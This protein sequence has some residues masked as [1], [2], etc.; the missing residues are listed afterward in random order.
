MDVI[1]YIRQQAEKYGWYKYFSVAR[2]V[3]IGTC[4]TSGIMDSVNYH[5]RIEVRSGLMAWGE[6]YYN[7]PLTVQEM[8]EYELIKA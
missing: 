1:T 8:R 4:P 2:P 6:I 3:D 5:E 7:R